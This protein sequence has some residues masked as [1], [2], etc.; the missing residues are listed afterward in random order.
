MKG[1][2]LGVLRNLCFAM[3]VLIVFLLV[4]ERQV[5]L[6]AWI[7]PIG[8]MHPLILHLPIGLLFAL[9]LLA[10][11]RAPSTNGANKSI[12]SYLLH[13]TAALAAVTALVG[14]FL[15]VQG[16]YDADA[17][18]WHKWTGVGVS[19]FSYFLLIVHNENWQRS[20]YHGLLAVTTA[21]L[22]Y[23]GHLGG[24]L[25]HG[26]NFVFGSSTEEEVLVINEFTPLY[27]ALVKPILKKKCFSCHNE[28]KSKGDL[29]M[30]DQ[31][32]FKKGGENGPSFIP[33]Q[34]DQSQIVQRIDLPLEEE[35]HMPPRSKTQLNDRE[36]EIISRWVASGAHFDLALKDY[37]REDPNTHW[38]AGQ[39]QNLEAPSVKYTFE[40]ADQDVVRSLNTPFRSV[41]QLD[42]NSPALDA[43]IF[44]R[45]NYE[46]SFLTE[47]DVVKNQLISLNLTNLPITDD[48][49]SSIA[50]FKQLEKLIL[51]GTD[52]NG[53]GL[54]YLG[55]CTALKSLGLSSTDVTFDQIKSLLEAT[56][57]RTISLWN[58]PL[59]K[60]EFTALN[61]SH[62]EVDINVGD[63]P[64]TTD[65][66]ALAPPSLANKRL[67]MGQGEQLRIKEMFDGVITRY[68]LDGS[69]PDSSSQIYQAPIAVSGL[70]NFKAKAYKGGWLDS[71]IS[72]FTILQ[73]GL[74]AD[75]VFLL[76][77]PNPKY[78][79][80]GAYSLVDL[81]KGGPREFRSPY[82]LGF[83][84]HP[85]EAVFH[86]ADRPSVNQVTLSLAQNIGAWAMPPQSIEI[87]GGED[88][89][90][91]SRLA[92]YRPEPAVEK[93]K[94]KDLIIEIALSGAKH[95][96]YKIKANQLPA[97]PSWHSRKGERAW[98]FVDEIL[99]Y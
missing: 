86:F 92:S 53:E 14:F 39:Y 9:G 75:T 99:F 60:D 63:L 51:N 12:E 17:V 90:H 8:R 48:E 2:L 6:P 3:Q 25:T 30:I 37:P 19:L 96:Y 94:V 40:F 64:S 16:D 62:P 95:P 66:I 57:L 54:Q 41:R 56:N 83:R 4:M 42:L 65:S 80:S 35:E 1:S 47:L 93:E 89:D 27:E 43:T 67:I 72:N 88:L 22:I 74:R 23:A 81:E 84:E 15:A 61:L 10:V 91:L 20:F 55:E 32:R 71:P 5:E 24:E 76:S 87:W 7:A 52:I 97:L 31:E 11:F 98:I 45:A 38:L 58:T 21:L 68:T 28:R 18:R 73:S 13:V 79:A 34:P 69:D 29:V 46:P 77:A 70:T 50:K 85:F 36:K 44:V 49:L 78:R 82:W 59:T 33:Y 26:E